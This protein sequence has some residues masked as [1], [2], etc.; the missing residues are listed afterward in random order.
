MPRRTTSIVLNQDEKG[1]LL[2][3]TQSHSL[4]QGLVQRAQIVLVDA[5][6]EPGSAIAARLHFLHFPPTDLWERSEPI[7]NR[8]ECFLYIK[9][10]RQSVSGS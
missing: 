3:L 7:H 4:S 5:G 10:N 8:V 9:Q 1:Q 6:G 2:S